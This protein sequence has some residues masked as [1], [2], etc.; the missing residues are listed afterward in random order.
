MYLAM[1]EVG[2]SSFRAEVIYF[3]IRTDFALEAW[4]NNTTAMANGE[5]RFLTVEYAN[6]IQGSQIDPNATLVS[7]LLRAVEQ[8]GIYKPVLPNAKVKSACEIALKKY[9]QME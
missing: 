2:L 8:N 6:I 4:N 5:S 3:G 1:L 7:I 9:Q